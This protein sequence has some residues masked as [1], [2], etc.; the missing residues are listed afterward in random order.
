MALRKQYFPS[1]RKFQMPQSDFLKIFCILFLFYILSPAPWS[2]HSLGERKTCLL[3]VGF[4]CGTL[5]VTD[6]LPCVRSLP[7]PSLPYQLWQSF[8][9]QN[10]SKYAH[11]FY[12]I[13]FYTMLV[14]IYLSDWRNW[15]YASPMGQAHFENTGLESNTWL[16]RV[17][18]RW[19]WGHLKMLSLF[20]IVHWD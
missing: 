15:F 11:L 12:S 6:F 7:S 3:P 4:F 14:N 20:V 2:Q 8:P 17:N 13:S 5:S 19:M 9:N 1:S 10:F 18:L 16:E